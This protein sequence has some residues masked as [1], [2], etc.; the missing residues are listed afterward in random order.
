LHFG[1]RNYQDYTTHHDAVRKKNYIARHSKNENW[2][3]IY[4]KGM[5]S[6]YLLWEKK[7]L[8]E[9]IDF[10]EKKFKMKII[11]HF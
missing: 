2:E 5:W 1:N 10:I 11:K 8:Q 6:R 3:N 7:S 9:A 4:S